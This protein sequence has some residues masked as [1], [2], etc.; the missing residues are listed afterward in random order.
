MQ[1]DL[2]TEEKVVPLSGT[3]VDLYDQMFLIFV[4]PPKALLPIKFTEK[5][6]TTDSSL[7]QIAN[8]SSPM[9]VTEA[10]I[11]M[12]VRDSHP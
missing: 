12:D 10:G 5:G 7:L 6:M 1:V 9:E 2:S 8:D 11:V 3:G 4:H